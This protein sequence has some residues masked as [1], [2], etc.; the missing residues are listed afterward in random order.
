M[1][2]LIIIVVFVAVALLNWV[3]TR[4]QS[5]QAALTTGLRKARKYLFEP[6]LLDVYAEQKGLSISEVEEQVGAGKIDAYCW[7][8]F[9]YVEGYSGAQHIEKKRPLHKKAT[10]FAGSLL[11]VYAVFGLFLGLLPVDTLN[12]MIGQFVERDSQTFYKIVAD[13]SQAF[14][15]PLCFVAAVALLMYSSIYSLERPPTP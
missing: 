6:M 10:F 3:C 11:L 4:K 1:V 9:T 12:Y 14:T 7:F 15:F 2:K 8:Q 5:N 13:D